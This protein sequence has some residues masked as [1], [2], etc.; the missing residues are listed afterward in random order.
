MRIIAA[1]N[2]PLENKQVQHLPDT[3]V[4]FFSPHPDD[5]Q[6]TFM[7]ATDSTLA[8]Y[9]VDNLRKLSSLEFTLASEGGADDVFAFDSGSQWSG[10]GDSR[11]KK[12]LMEQSL[13]WCKIV[14]T[15]PYL[16][17]FASKE[18]FAV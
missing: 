11:R 3:C 4:Y 2:L 17:L 18:A 10:F 5:V 16:F 6:T 14:S 12:S 9:C 13:E 8:G 15:L 1:K 7:E